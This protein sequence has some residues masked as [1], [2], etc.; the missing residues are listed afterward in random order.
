MTQPVAFRGDP[1]VK[2]ALLAQIDRHLAAGTLEYGETLWD[3]ERG[4]AMGV[5]IEGTDPAVYAA[6]YGY[7]LSLVVLLDELLRWPA[8]GFDTVGFVRDWVKVV[9]PGAD[10]APAATRL[11][12]S[13]LTDP[14]LARIDDA[15]IRAIAALHEADLD[16]RPATRA[17]WATVRQS[18]LALSTD[19][20]DSRHV[21]AARLCEA[22]AW[23]AARGR[24]TLVS[25]F[26]AW[27]AMHAHI[28]DAAWSDADEA[29]KDTLLKMIWHD[30]EA[31]RDRNE[32][33][34]YGALLAARDD[35][36]AK[37]FEAN[38]RR[39]NTNFQAASAV[40]ADHCIAL[41]HAC[42]PVSGRSPI[43]SS[44]S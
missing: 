38:L 2:A 39:S 31:A 32:M 25:A 10:L 18:V 15:L 24:S 7:P 16:G 12:L 35:A 17:Q 27:R 23:P 21:I 26:H 4:S 41:L 1:A 30:Q 9:M 5:S 19:L 20:S 44:A 11:M 29:R 40:I 37:G 36:L 3:G 42:K 22:A 33:V 6:D 13:M 28:R 8:P 14:G 34:D 43:S